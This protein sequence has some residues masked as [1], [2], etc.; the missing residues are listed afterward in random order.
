MHILVLGATSDMALALTAEFAK[1]QGGEFTLAAR[2]PSDLEQA[3][4]DLTVRFQVK[5]RVK[6]FDALDYPSHGPFYESLHCR[7]DVVVVA[8]GYLGDQKK[9]EE[10]FEE[11]KKILAVNFLGAASI[12]EIVAADFERIKRGAIIC[13]SSVAG[14][15]GRQSNYAYGSAKGGLSV[16]LSGL[17]HRLHWANVTVTTVLPGFVRTKMTEGLD[18][19]G[20]L[21][22]QPEQAARD[23]YAGW[24][25]KR[26]IVYTRWFWRYI[27]MII[28]YL[29]EK[30]FLR[31]K[32]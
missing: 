27:M 26:S 17:R 29:P 20:L 14:E 32:L 16:F 5:V 4:K 1:N 12:L 7:P 11:M 2:R 30:I 18:L 23:I 25:K 6:A 19:P 21:T 8:F 31:T 10:D 24:Q 13:I 15:R 3:A 28:R 22:A 9:A